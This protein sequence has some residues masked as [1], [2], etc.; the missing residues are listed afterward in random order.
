MMMKKENG[1]P[2]LA[3]QQAQDSE[4]G[5]PGLELVIELDITFSPRRRRTRSALRFFTNAPKARRWIMAGGER[6]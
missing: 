6:C 1:D 2:E 3:H 4:E 5:V